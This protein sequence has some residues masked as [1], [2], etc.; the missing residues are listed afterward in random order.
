VLSYLVASHTRPELNGALLGVRQDSRWFRFWQESRLDV[1]PN[2]IAIS[3]ISVKAHLAPRPYLIGNFS[4]SFFLSF[5]RQRQG[6]FP[7]APYVYHL[8]GTYQS[9]SDSDRSGDN[10]GRVA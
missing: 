9:R 5:S 8:R 6:L 3:V 2:K 1:E 10:G 7:S 4:D